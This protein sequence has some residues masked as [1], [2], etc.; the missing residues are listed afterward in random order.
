MNILGRE[1]PPF[2]ALV[3]DIAN[4][5]RAAVATMIP[6]HLAS[7]LA[8]PELAWTALGGWLGTLADP[9]GSKSARA[10]AIVLFVALGS[11]SLALAELCAG[12]V[13]LA[14]G[15]LVTAVF[16]GTLL[17]ALGGASTTL[18]TMLAVVVAIASVSHS[19]APLRDAG[20]FA[21]GATWA[22]TLSTVVWP[23]WTHLPVR[24][25]LGTVFEAMAG[26]AASLEANLAEQRPYGDDAWIHGARTHRRK[27]RDAIENA[28][29]MALAIRARRAGESRVGGNLRVL[30][31]LVEA[32]FA[33]LIA[34]AEDLEAEGPARRKAGRRTLDAI[35]RRYGAIHRTLV[36]NVIT[37]KRARPAVTGIKDVLPT[38][39]RSFDGISDRLLRSSALSVLVSSDLDAQHDGTT[40][41]E[42]SPRR[43]LRERVAGWGTGL[44]TLRDAL[45]PE[46]PHFRH[47]LR[48]AGAAA[49]AAIIGQTVSPDHATWVTV[50]TIAILQP[51]PGAT[52]VRAA[53]RVIGT[54]FGSVAAVVITMT[55]RS[56]LGLL[57]VM[58]PMCV[59]AVATRARSYRLFTFFLTPIF[60]LLAERYP[61]DWW[62]A[63]V[64]AGDSALGGAI[65]LV[66]ALLV[67]PSW[68]HTRLPDALD[69]M[70]DRALAYAKVVFESVG[71]E[72]DQART[73]DRGARAIEG[74]RRACGVGLSEAEASLER[75]LAEPIRT[76]D[77]RSA[78]SMQLV[79]YLRRLMGALT[80][81]EIRLH[82]E[83][84][85]EAVRVA[86]VRALDDARI[87]AF[88]T[89]VLRSVQGWVRDPSAVRVAPAPPRPP[90]DLDPRARAIVERLLAHTAL[91]AS[92]AAPRDEAHDGE[93][94]VTSS[95]VRS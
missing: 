41:G 51:Y 92:L 66:A 63:A 44:R 56:Q 27:V 13:W 90:A 20:L 30:L 22:M 95:P 16:L 59:A 31:G 39:E 2:E 45:S 7:S 60:V 46:S 33:L 17:R 83:S 1:R 37:P 72:G 80:A 49:C 88:V 62:T 24:R 86:L 40:A 81:L 94:R 84:T 55:V 42:L 8:R 15:A 73:S 28:R 64:R 79:T 11:A 12:Q 6:F 61:G 32:Q 50:T 53:E 87:A 57:L 5:V 10:R 71:A 70:V 89:E 74:A 54:V 93:R 76:G 3:P 47:A 21:L 35:R 25:A 85:D 69:T 68:E 91:V 67:F 34:L 4:G 78:D 77:H 58:F 43:T 65:A 52:W 75:M 23:V 26:Y 18:G 19:H 36:T 38:S 29:A 82:H 48:V 9:G 14:T